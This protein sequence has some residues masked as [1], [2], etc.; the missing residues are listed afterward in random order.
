MPKIGAEGFYKG[1]VKG[2]CIMK[3]TLNALSSSHVDAE[4]TRVILRDL[5]R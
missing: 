4:Q 2:T 5:T 3:T 1:S